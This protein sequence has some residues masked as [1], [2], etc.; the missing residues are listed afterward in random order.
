M[1]K[2]YFTPQD[3]VNKE[4]FTSDEVFEQNRKLTLKEWLA[5]K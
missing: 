4:L 5:G 2:D 1:S 3:P